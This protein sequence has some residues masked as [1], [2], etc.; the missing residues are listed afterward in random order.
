[1]ILDI[2]PVHPAWEQKPAIRVRPFDMT[3]FWP[4]RIGPYV[5]HFMHNPSTVIGLKSPW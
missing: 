2:F 3:I 5:L 4:S 1:M